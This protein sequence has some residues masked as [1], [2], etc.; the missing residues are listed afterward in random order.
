M[1]LVVDGERG[2]GRVNVVGKRWREKEFWMPV[3]K[4]KSKRELILLITLTNQV[5][6]WCAWSSRTP[7]PAPL[8]ST[9]VFLTFLCFALD[10]FHLFYALILVFQAGKHCFESQRT[11][12]SRPERAQ[13]PGSFIC[14]GR[15]DEPG[16][17]EDTM[18]RSTCS[19]FHPMVPLC[20][21]REETLFCFS[22]QPAT[23]LNLMF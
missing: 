11:A 4:W 3:S 1:L 6:R 21:R 17:Q 9:S 13:R 15:N 16:S 7:L 5:D 10:L 22:A 2:T 18:P 14:K 12:K 19:S 23:Y 8:C 20:Q